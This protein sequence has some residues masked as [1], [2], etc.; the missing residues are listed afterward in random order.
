MFKY[1]IVC[2]ALCSLAV[3][4]QG[5]SKLDV[6]FVKCFMENSLTAE[7]IAQI[8]RKEFPDEPEVRPLLLCLSQA[9][10]IFSI[11]EGFDID[12]LVKG[13]FKNLSKEEKQQIIH[14]CVDSN[15][16]K[17]PADEWVFRVHKCL[18]ISDTGDLA[19]AK[20]AEA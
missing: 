15:E 2:L 7:Q 13:L 19:R 6:G 8:M 11:S 5:L 10:H 17:S 4:E 18:Y 1:F 12:L 20:K 14:K 9:L 3:S 16:Q